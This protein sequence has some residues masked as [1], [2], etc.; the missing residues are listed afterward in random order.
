M[1]FVRKWKRWVC[2]KYLELF[3]KRKKWSMTSIYSQ[4]SA[5]LSWELELAWY[6]PIQTPHVPLKYLYHQHQFPIPYFSKSTWNWKLPHPRRVRTNDLTDKVPFIYHCVQ[7]SPRVLSLGFSSLQRLRK[8]RLRHLQGLPKLTSDTF[9]L[10]KRP[11]LAQYCHKAS[12]YK[13]LKIICLVCWCMFI[14]RADWL[15]LS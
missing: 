2:S 4:I 3:R 9:H 15:C 13:N 1:I 8:A 11:V 5:K 14:W 10:Q 6:R 7:S 12:P